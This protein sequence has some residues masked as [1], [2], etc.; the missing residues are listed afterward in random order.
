MRIS[1]VPIWC[2]SAALA[3]FAIG[4]GARREPPPA[5]PPHTGAADDATVTVK[6]F[7]WLEGTWTKT[8]ETSVLEEVWN[9]PLADSVS[10]TFRWVRAG[11]TWMY[12]L[13]TIEQD[14]EGIV[15]RLRHFGRNLK[16]WEKEEALAYPLK[17]VKE[18][19]AVFENLEPGEG[20]PV[21]LR[22]VRDGDRLIVTLEEEVDPSQSFEFTRRR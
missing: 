13:M 17:T 9:A 20:H 7:A 3:I 12:E 11:K 15:L 19:E 8:D 22:Y 6:N 21:R 18:N 2:A 1:H 10:G 5:P 4:L 14:A 16:P